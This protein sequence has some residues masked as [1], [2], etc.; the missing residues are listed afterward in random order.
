ME[1]TRLSTKIDNASGT[2]IN[3]ASIESIE[4]VSNL[5]DAIHEL[6]SRLEFLS[7][8]RDVTGGIRTV[9]LASAGTQTVSVSNTPSVTVTG[10]PNVA[11]TGQTSFGGYPNSN[12]PMAWMNITAHQA[13]IQNVTIS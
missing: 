9:A 10:T 3:P 5:V 2:I 12:I 11:V 1:P 8:A 7:S 4:A 6:V 13:N